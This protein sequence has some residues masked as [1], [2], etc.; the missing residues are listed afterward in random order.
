VGQIKTRIIQQGYRFAYNCFRFKYM[1]ELRLYEREARE[2]KGNWLLKPV[3][4][5][6]KNYRR[7][8]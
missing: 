4:L 7:Q 3:S 8:K 1:E 2:N 6:A 5:I